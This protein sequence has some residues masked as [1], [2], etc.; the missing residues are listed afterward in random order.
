[1][2]FIADIT[3]WWLIPIGAIAFALTYVFYQ[4][5]GWLNE[6][7]SSIRKLLF[8]LR[9]LS[10]TLIGLLL[11]GLMIEST[12]LRKE[13]PVFIT[14]VDNSSSLKNFSDSSQVLEQIKKFHSELKEKYPDKFE[15]VS[16][17][18]GGSFRQTNDFD[19]KDSKSKLDQG[20]E[21]VYNR[22]Y[23]RN[24]GGITF[25][26][27]GN[28]NDGESPI[29]PAQKIAM[30]PIF[31]L[32]VGDTTAKK[33]QLISD[34]THNEIAFLKNKFPVEIDV[35][36]LKV[37]RVSSKV[38]IFHKD[39][40]VAS[41]VIHY[42]SGEFDHKHLNFE[43]E[44][45]EIG[46]QHYT[47]E[48]LPLTGE[49][50]VKNNYRSF[51]IEVLD[52]RNKILILSG[53]P[54]PDLSAL[55][56]VLEKDENVEVEIQLMEKWQPNLQKVDLIIWHEPGVN[57]NA[58]K[59]DFIRNSGLPIWYFIG[60]NTPNSMVQKLDLGFSF[61][62]S[63]Q[64]D[65]VQAKLNAGFESF[66]ISDELKQAF[67]YFPAVKV[68]YGETKLNAQNKVLLSQRLGGFAKNDPILF[69][70]EKGSFKYG[71][72]FG[73]GI[74]KWKINE[75]SRTNASES[76]EELIQKVSQFLVVKQN[77]SALRIAM[78][79]RFQKGTEIRIK[80]SF[81]NESLEAITT[82]KVMFELTDESGKKSNY[83]FAEKLN[84][85]QLP[86][87]IL[88]PGKFSWIAKTEFGGKKYAKSGVFIVEDID[89]ES[90]ETRANHTL[91][92]QLST[93][94]N[95]TFYPLKSYKKLI[96]DL[97][98]REDIVDVTYQE[99]TNADLLDYVLVLLLIS[100][101]LSLEWFLRRRFGGY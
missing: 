78:P 16:Y 80:A 7:S 30:T 49:Y 21:Q 52:A 99:K 71:V 35:E 66:Q 27:D 12:K 50:T 74:W 65:E 32:G 63:R 96:E 41:Q 40:L 92:K 57:F 55:K 4:K 81:Y 93:N 77:S 36:A 46:F 13:K 25:I 86:L 9:F 15:F 88:A 48:V 42:E 22:Y 79:S 47:V 90:I 68:P 26:S 45:N 73:E 95:G 83:Q 8:I 64:T 28:F 51:Y 62:N 43:L 56:S 75:Y 1:M 5:K 17:A 61:P 54:H 10:L 59:F 98:Q 11:L 101:L 34:V 85:Y 58:S 100:F 72:F 53:A 87:G 84:G 94:S 31:T 29:Y 24:I 89:I 14:L 39:K 6:I 97:A 44:A 70:G 76:F 19:L 91:L 60:P 23:N 67:N 38:S 69:V 82:P 18:V 37:G 20:F 3:W 2:R 33:D